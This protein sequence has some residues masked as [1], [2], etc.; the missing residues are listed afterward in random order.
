M[1]I[2]QTVYKCQHCH[3]DMKFYKGGTAT[4]FATYIC[5]I[6]QALFIITLRKSLNKI[7]IAGH[8]I[9]LDNRGA[10]DVLKREYGNES[11]EL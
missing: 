9:I 7:K 2:Q 5:E 3:G 8:E 6:C 11:N 10:F 1:G 4:M